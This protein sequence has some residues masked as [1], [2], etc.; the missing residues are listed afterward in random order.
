MTNDQTPP[1]D[2]DQERA[3]ADAA[4]HAD[5]EEMAD[6]FDIDDDA[7][8]STRMAP[9]EAEAAAETIQAAAMQIETLDNEVASLKDRL[10]REMAEME[11]L[12]K[13]SAREKADATKFAITGFARDMINVGDNLNRALQALPEDV[14]ENAADEI[15]NL[16]VGVE[17]TNQ[18]MLNVFDRN[19]IKQL[20]PIDEKFNPNFHQT[21]FE[22]P[23][24]DVVSGTVVEVV[25]VGY[26]IGDRILRPALVGVA[27]GGPKNVVDIASASD[28]D[29]GG[30]I[31]TSA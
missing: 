4:A 9:S 31:D 6:E 12:R 20:N 3:F 10:L 15:K 19:G 25:Q 1:M 13:R 7:T 14:R 11:N 30:S 29:I 28:K 18:E 27:K 8:Q 23:N 26:A 22:V 21:M 5:A 17:M 16:F 24:E 2:A